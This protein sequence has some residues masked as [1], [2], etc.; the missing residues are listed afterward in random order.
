MEDIWL[1]HSSERNPYIQTSKADPGP[2]PPPPPTTP[3]Q[4]PPKRRKKHTGVFLNYAGFFFP[5]K[6]VR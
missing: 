1:Q 4:T 3:P 5:H 2:P 6:K